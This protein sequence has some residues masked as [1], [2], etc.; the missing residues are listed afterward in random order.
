ME[1]DA[2]FRNGTPDLIPH[3]RAIPKQTIPSR[4]KLSWPSYPSTI[5]AGTVLEKNK[6]N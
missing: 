6:V 2:G 1:C 5:A 3:Y 4:A